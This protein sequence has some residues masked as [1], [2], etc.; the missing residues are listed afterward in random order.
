MPGGRA[1]NRSNPGTRW[2]KCDW[3]NGLKKSAAVDRSPVQMYQ[4]FVWPSGRWRSP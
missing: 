1:K 3:C 2:T 4:P